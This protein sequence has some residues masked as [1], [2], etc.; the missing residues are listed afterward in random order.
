[1][2]QFDALVFKGSIWQLNSVTGQV[3]FHSICYYLFTKISGIHSWLHLPVRK[4]RWT[5][6][7]KSNG[8]I[9]PSQYSGSY[10]DPKYWLGSLWDWWR[11][12]Q[13]NRAVIGVAMIMKQC[14]KAATM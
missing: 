9:I 6:I 2:Q 13:Y 3:L 14:N 11:L 10:P 5:E 8:E 4:S 1:M 12:P 7:E